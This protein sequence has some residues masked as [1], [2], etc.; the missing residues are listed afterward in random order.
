[1]KY[2]QTLP[3]T[4]MAILDALTIC[5]HPTQMGKF[6]T[7]EFGFRYS[8]PLINLSTTKIHRSVDE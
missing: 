8:R 5:P 1:M 3:E 2:M 7:L 6:L 4:R